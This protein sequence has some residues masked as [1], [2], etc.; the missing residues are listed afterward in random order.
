MATLGKQPNVAR[1]MRAAASPSTL[2]LK[3]ADSLSR[4]TDSDPEG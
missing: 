3:A 4:D 1:T 2:P